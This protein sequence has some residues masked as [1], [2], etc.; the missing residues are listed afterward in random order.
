MYNRIW[1]NNFIYKIHFIA[2][3]CEDTG[4][5]SFHADKTAI[6][7]WLGYFSEGKFMAQLNACRV[8]QETC[9]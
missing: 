4:D 8:I 9:T 1:E 7:R 5:L 3:Y 6:H 2:G